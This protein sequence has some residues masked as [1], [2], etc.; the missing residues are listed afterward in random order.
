MMTLETRS[1]A[2]AL[3]GMR[4]LVVDDTEDNVVMLQYLFELAGAKT[5]AA[6][7]AADALRIAAAEDFD[8]VLSDISMPKMDGFEFLRRLRALPG[9]QDVPVLAITGF[10]RPEDIER[11]L[12]E[13]FFSH[14]TKPFDLKTLTEILQMATKR[15]RQ[16]QKRDSID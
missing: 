10:S 4:I 9:K 5:I 11:A 12:S 16:G 8:V 14:L 7:S 13:G 3:N 15:K 6:T 2:S 1:D